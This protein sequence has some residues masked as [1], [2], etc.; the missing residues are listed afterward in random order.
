MLAEASAG[1]EKGQKVGVAGQ[2]RM[3]VADLNASSGRKSR[4]EVWNGKALF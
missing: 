4:W 1:F 3:P 2:W